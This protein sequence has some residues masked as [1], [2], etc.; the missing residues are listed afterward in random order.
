MDAQPPRPARD[1]VRTETRSSAVS[2]P[3]RRW[4]WT[5]PLEISLGDHTLALGGMALTVGVYEALNAG[6]PGAGGWA[7]VISTDTACTLGALSLVAPP[8]ATRLGVFRLTVTAVDEL[9]A[10]L[11]G[12][13]LA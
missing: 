3:R 10:L 6:G 11:G 9:V 5:T 7:A 13:A 1:L 4:R 8:G 2:W 12:R